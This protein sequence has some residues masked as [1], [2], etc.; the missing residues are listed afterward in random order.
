MR[1]VSKEIFHFLQY[2]QY[3]IQTAPD[4][5]AHIYL[6]H[7][8]LM[9][10]G[11]YRE[12]PLKIHIGLTCFSVMVTMTTKFQNTKRRVNLTI[13]SVPISMFDKVKTDITS[14]LLVQHRQRLS[15]V[16]QMFSFDIGC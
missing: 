14:V 12:N 11:V 4:V 10:Q 13:P 2:L 8:D 6:Y 9:R 5:L 3:T 1:L 15:L 16:V 7:G